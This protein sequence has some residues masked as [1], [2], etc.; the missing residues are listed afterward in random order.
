[1]KNTIKLIIALLL[2]LFLSS[3]ISDSNYN[4]DEL[5]KELNEKYDYNLQTE[6]FSIFEDEPYK[7]NTII[8]TNILITLYCN[9]NN[10]IEQCT[11]TSEKNTESFNRISKHIT[12]I[13]TKKSNYKDQ[14]NSEYNGWKIITIENKIGKT[15][16]INKSD[17]KI[18][19]TNTQ[20]EIT[21]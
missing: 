16:L 12:E 17:N 18:H 5:I 21:K 3:C 11:I 2:I 4:I 9:A 10:E 1:M 15:I 7:Y 19:K 14:N 20:K 8:E 6:D 13:L